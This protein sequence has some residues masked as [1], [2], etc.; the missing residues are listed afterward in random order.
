MAKGKKE[1]PWAMISVLGTTAWLL[2][3]YFEKQKEASAA[4]AI[5]YTNPQTGTNVNVALPTTQITPTTPAVPV[6]SSSTISMPNITGMT[7][8][9]IRTLASQMAALGMT[10]EATQLNTYADQMVT[11]GVQT[12][13]AASI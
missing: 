11:K 12:A 10:A 7:S 9:A 8:D 6:T 1:I 13:P 5:S 4:P 3:D 2:Y